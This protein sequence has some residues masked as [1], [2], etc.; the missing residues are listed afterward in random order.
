MYIVYISE[1]HPFDGWHIKTAEQP[2]VLSHRSITD[3]LEAVKYFVQDRVGN[4]I[5][6]LYCPVFTKTPMYILIFDYRKKFNF[7]PKFL[8]FG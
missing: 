2:K 3:R 5:A 4:Y 7:L 8:F 1:A 6:K